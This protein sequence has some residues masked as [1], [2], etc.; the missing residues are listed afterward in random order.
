MANFWIVHRE[1]QIRAALAHLARAGAADLIGAPSD[2]RF[3]DAAAPG[4]IL[5]GLTGDF[6]SELEFAHRF[7]RRH[8]GA[9]WIVLADRRDLGEGQRLFDAVPAEFVAYP[10]NPAALRAQLR[11]GSPGARSGAPALSERRVRDAVATRFAR[12]FCGVEIPELLRALE[13]RM[14]RVPLLLWGERGTG[15]ALVARYLHTFGNAGIGEAGTFAPVACAETDTPDS[16]LERIGM[17]AGEQRISTLYFED[18]ERLPGATQRA[19]LWWIDSGAPPSVSVTPELR[20][21]GSVTEIGPFDPPANLDLELVQAL[22]GIEVRLP[23]LREEPT[24]VVASVREIAH[25]WSE[26]QRERFRQFD[27]SAL[28]AL[29]IYPWPGNRREL[30]RV[31]CRT[32]A[33]SS[34]DPVRAEHLRFDGGPVDHDVTSESAEEMEYGARPTPAFDRSPQRET[35][36]EFSDDVPES[37]ADF[38]QP[39]EAPDERDEDNHREGPEFEDSEPEEERDAPTPLRSETSVPIEAAEPPPPVEP[40]APIA[41]APPIEPPPSVERTRRELE[42]AIAKGALLDDD[43][44]QKLV[45]AVAHEIRNPLV[46]IRTFAQLL[47]R[48]FEDPEF[49]ARSGPIVGSEVRRIEQLIELMVRFAGLDAPK[50]E[51]VD[52]PALLE[53]LLEDRREAIEQ[54]P[55]VV[56]KELDRDQPYAHGDAEQLRFAL[57]AVIAKVLDLVSDQGDL[58]LASKHHPQ[59]LGEG[60]SVR[61]LLR[62]RGRGPISSDVSTRG[63]SLVESS[64][65]LALAEAIVQRHGGRFSVN[66][67]DPQDTVIVIDLPA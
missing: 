36:I 11:S 9:N 42:A 41:P 31:V 3:S 60:A 47:P 39:A 35:E 30:E 48:R 10:P 16:L 5:L 7:A 15:R 45:G 65:S 50:P 34:D 67:S 55:I 37:G 43:A 57:D 19:L 52:I 56:L 18:V 61:V 17:L 8:S 14:V 1:P 13:P 51:P 64:I 2:P 23:T 49:R 59:G 28:E 53:T 46:S 40:A 63:T 66:T 22:A 38:S 33:A 26:T 20:W 62:F 24:S 4:S 27:A 54:R 12:L 58:Y 25:A 32:L 21:I 6:E 29:R 44:I